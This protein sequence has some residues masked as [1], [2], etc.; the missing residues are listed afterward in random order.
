MCAQNTNCM[1]NREK[2]AATTNDI[3]NWS[4]HLPR[5]R[6][7]TCHEVMAW[8]LAQ[9]PLQSWKSSTHVPNSKQ[10]TCMDMAQGF[11]LFAATWFSHSRGSFPVPWR[12]GW[13]GQIQLY[14]SQLWWGRRCRKMSWPAKAFGFQR[15]CPSLA[16]GHQF[17]LNYTLRIVHWSLSKCTCW[18]DIIPN[19][20][21]Y[22]SANQL[23]QFKKHQGSKHQ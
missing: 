21:Q 2:H 14:S 12:S 6:A 20:V 1:S 8:Y 4:T 17:L 11:H 10:N 5:P 13:W 9:S 19:P 18:Q 3:E 7:S 16:G 15:L 22:L 23:K